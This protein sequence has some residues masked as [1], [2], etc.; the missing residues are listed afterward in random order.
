MEYVSCALLPIVRVRPIRVHNTRS[1][2]KMWKKTHG[3]TDVRPRGGGGGVGGH[4]CDPRRPR[5]S[6]KDE[7][8]TSG[9]GGGRRKRDRRK[10]ERAARASPAVAGSSGRA[11]AFRRRFRHRGRCCARDEF[12]LS[13]DPDKISGLK[14]Y[15]HRRMVTK[16]NTSID[17]EEYK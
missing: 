7:R 10:C 16:S 1:P 5:G 13:I 9:G 12:V 8:V 17:I 3:R 15:P 11:R 14:K 4:E 6:P 2:C